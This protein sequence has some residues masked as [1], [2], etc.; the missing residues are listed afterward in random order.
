MNH[1]A[2]ED[3]FVSLVAESWTVQPSEISMAADASL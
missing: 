1:E 3:V 2:H